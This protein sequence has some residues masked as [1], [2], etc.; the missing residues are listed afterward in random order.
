MAMQNKNNKSFVNMIHD[1]L[2]RNKQ[3]MKSAGYS[4]SATYTFVGEAAKLLENTEPTQIKM[5]KTNIKEWMCFW[6][7]SILLVSF[8]IHSSFITKAEM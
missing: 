2:M 7:E 1:A 5:Y 6:Y 3:Y 8:F 4:L